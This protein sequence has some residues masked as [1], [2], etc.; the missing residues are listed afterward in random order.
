M[1]SSIQSIFEMK[2]EVAQNAPL[3]GSHKVKEFNARLDR[4]IRYKEE[5]A[6]SELRQ[7]INA[8]LQERRMDYTKELRKTK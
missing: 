4:Q 5:F 1:S 8:L 6:I 7:E 3:F 2:A